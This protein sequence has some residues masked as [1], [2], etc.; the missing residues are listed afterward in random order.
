MTQTQEKGTMCNDCY[1]HIKPCKLEECMNF[2][3]DSCQC[4]KCKLPPRVE[5]SWGDWNI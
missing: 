1:D 5:F 3:K 2:G 4:E